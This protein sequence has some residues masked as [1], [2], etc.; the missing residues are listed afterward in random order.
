LSDTIIL[1]NNSVDNFIRV[2]DRLFEL[3][4]TKGGNSFYEEIPVNTSEYK[5]FT[6]SQPI[7][8]VNID[9]YGAERL[10][11]NLAVKT[12]KLYSKREE[13]K[14]NGENFECL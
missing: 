10:D 14:I 7:L 12:E 13:E 11:E 1:K 8:S 3:V 9:N 6:I 4:D 5:T 2:K